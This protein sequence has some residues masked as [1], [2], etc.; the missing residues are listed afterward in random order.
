M[1][2]DSGLWIADLEE[3][4]SKI[5]NSKSKTSL[6]NTLSNEIDDLLIHAA[7]DQL[8]SHS[9]RVLDRFGFASAVADDVVAAYP[10]QRRAAVLLPVV[11]GVNLLHDRLELIQH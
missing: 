8:F 10:Q 4:Q 6:L 3:V 5:R 7:G 1:I 11:A 9:D 2:L